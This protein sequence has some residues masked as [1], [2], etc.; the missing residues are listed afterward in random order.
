MIKFSEF[1][2]DEQI[3]YEI[4]ESLIKEK[5]ITVYRFCKDTGIAQATIIDWRNG[6]SKPK[7]D[8]IKKIADYFDVSIDYLMGE[9]KAKKPLI[10][11]DEELTEYL[12]ALKNREDMR[13]LFSISKD[14]TIEEVKQAVRIIEALRKKD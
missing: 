10:N 3:M 14:C 7:A 5:G 8:K 12:E 6:K 9:T 13:M 11:E 1:V 2:E 4:F